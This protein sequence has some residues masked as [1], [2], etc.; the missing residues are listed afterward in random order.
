[1]ILREKAVMIYHTGTR[2]LIRAVNNY[3]YPIQDRDGV[4]MIRHD[5]RYHPEHSLVMLHRGYIPSSCLLCIY[6]ELLD[7]CYSSNT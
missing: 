1:M 6:S 3:R 5:I 7:K 2:D 4:T